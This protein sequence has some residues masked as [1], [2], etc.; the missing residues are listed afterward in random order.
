MR[1]ILIFCIL[2]LSAVALMPVEGMAA[3]EQMPDADD[4]DKWVI[5]LTDTRSSR[6]KGWSTGVGY[7]GSYDY[8][9]DPQLRRLAKAVA[10]DYPV[11]VL[12]QWPVRALNVHCVVVRITGDQQQTLDGL[13]ADK[14]V[15]WVQPLN[16]FEALST[17][18]LASAGSGDDPYRHLQSSLEMLNVAP[19]RRQL[20]GA[21]VSVVVIDSAVEADHPDLRHALAEQIDFVGIDEPLSCL[22][23]L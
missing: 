20:T 15:E 4:R 23:G 16:T 13:T 14:R 3:D 7:S 9:A 12:D 22:S 18:M 1:A 21:G 11:Q 8:A 10:K 5:V 2:L 6:R 19:L 17:A